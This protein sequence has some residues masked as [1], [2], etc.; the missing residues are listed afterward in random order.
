M[1]LLEVKQILKYNEE[2]NNKEKIKNYYKKYKKELEDFKYIDNESYFNKK[3]RC[4]VRYIGFNNKLYYGGFYVKSEKKNNTLYIYLINTKK[5]IWY[6]DFNKN[7]VFI[8]KVISEDD[9]I[10]K[11]FVEFLEKNN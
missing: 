1:K 10:R 3:K 8:N 11:S 6:I 2:I 7:Y 5:Q 4:Y 9:K